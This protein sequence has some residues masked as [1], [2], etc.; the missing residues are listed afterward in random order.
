MKAEELIKKFPSKVV[1]NGTLVLK[2]Q[3][4]FFKEKSKPK[5]P[6]HLVDPK[7]QI[8]C[9]CGALEGQLFPHF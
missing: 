9:S 8:D 6:C 5:Q 3:V 2:I 7:K 4:A 1:L